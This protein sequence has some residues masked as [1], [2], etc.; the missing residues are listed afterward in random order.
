MGLAPLHHKAPSF[1]NCKNTTWYFPHCIVPFPLLRLL[2][3]A[4]TTNPCTPYCSSWNT[5]VK[6][7]KL[8]CLLSGS[9]LLGITEGSC[10]ASIP[11]NP[12]AWSGR[13]GGR[14]GSSCGH[15]GR[16]IIQLSCAFFHSQ[17]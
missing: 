4:S 5:V 6:M 15:V 16:C 9:L 10:M 1:P 11:P 3:V 2:Q 12:K 7:D 17:W 13:T 8:V 14:A